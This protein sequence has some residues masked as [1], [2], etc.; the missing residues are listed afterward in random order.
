MKTIKSLGITAAL[1]FCCHANAEMTLEGKAEACLPGEPLD[2]CVEKSQINFFNEPNIGQ[3]EWRWQPAA[4]PLPEEA[5][6]VHRLE[7]VGNN[8][9]YIEIDGRPEGYFSPLVLAGGY[10]S[11]KMGDTEAVTVNDYVLSSISLLIDGRV[12]DISYRMVIGY[13]VD[14][15]VIKTCIDNAC[16]SYDAPFFITF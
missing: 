3:M 16:T 13:G 6:G 15:I 1:L 9:V 2:Q 14:P 5:A 10:S 8:Q 4:D 12:V 11:L 7:F